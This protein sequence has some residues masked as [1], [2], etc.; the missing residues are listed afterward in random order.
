[1]QYITN[2]VH[3]YTRQLEHFTNFLEIF[4]NILAHLPNV[5]YVL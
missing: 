1:M 4:I 2:L 5:D 3:K